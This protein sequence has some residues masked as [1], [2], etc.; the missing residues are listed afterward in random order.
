MTEN[1]TYNYTNPPTPENTSPRRPT[2]L[3]SF[4]IPRTPRRSNSLSSNSSNHSQTQILP[5][6]QL[7]DSPQTPSTIPI[8]PVTLPRS[9]YNYTTET[10]PSRST[11]HL[12]ITTQNQHTIPPPENPS[13]IQPFRQSTNHLQQFVTF[14]TNLLEHFRRITPTATTQ[15]ANEQ[16]P[17]QNFR[18]YTPATSSNSVI[19]I[20]SDP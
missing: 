7:D 3:F 12:R 13:Q 19:N 16:R 15:P 14:I 1:T 9:P 6:Q 18:L 10:L 2:R 5:T 11:Q 4:R 20:D 8:P 17:V